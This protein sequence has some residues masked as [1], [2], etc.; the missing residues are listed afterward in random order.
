MYLAEYFNT[1]ITNK[2]PILALGIIVVVNV[3]AVKFF[4]KQF[5]K[6]PRT[7]PLGWLLLSILS[8][9]IIPSGVIPAFIIAY[10][11]HCKVGTNEVNAIFDKI[12]SAPNETLVN[13]FMEMVK[14][15]NLP[16]N[17]KA[18][19]Q[20]RGV[21]FVVNDCPNISTAKKTEFRNFLMSVGLR[22]VGNDKNVTDNYNANFNSDMQEEINRQNMELAMEESR[23]AVTPFD[24]GG[25]VQGDGFNP[26]DTMV[27]DAQREQM[28][29]MNNM[30]MF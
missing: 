8:G 27:A 7:F 29:Q 15:Y 13:Q 23:K 18:W 11:K 26:S 30:N 12:M 24:M 16:N 10:R 5:M 20:V 9:L 19:N 28:N 14:K 2:N 1:Y 4:R 21:W 25:Y 3:L 17:P 22:L 6:K